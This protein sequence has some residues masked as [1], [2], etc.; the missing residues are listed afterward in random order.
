M[1]APPDP[2]TAELLA[3]LTT[4]L[5]AVMGDD[6]LLAVDITLETRFDDDLAMESL[7]F[8]ALGERLRERYGDRVDFPA[9]IAGLDVDEIMGLTVGDLLAFVSRQLDDSAAAV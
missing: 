3:E 1:T 5:V 2:R 9:F 8:V 7:E 6:V 4:E